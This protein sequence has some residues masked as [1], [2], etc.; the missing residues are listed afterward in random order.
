MSESILK[1]DQISKKYPGVQALKDINLEITRGE[2]HALCG[3]NG[4][5]KSTLIKILAGVR[6][7]DGGKLYIDGEEITQFNPI[8]AKKKGVSVMYQ[9]LDLAPNLTA[10]ENIVLGSEPLTKTHMFMDKKKSYESVVALF[11]RLKISVPLTVPV[12]KLSVAQQQMIMIAKSLSFN[13]KI[14]VMDEPT[15]TLIEKDVEKLFDIVRDLKKNGMTIIY[16]SHRLEEIFEIADRVTVFRDGQQV[17]T[18]DLEGLEKCDLIRYMIG[19]EIVQDTHEKT[20][21]DAAE[22][23]LEAKNLYTAKL[24]NVSIKLHRGEILGLAGLVGSG[25]TELARAIFGADKLISGEVKLFNQ[26][27]KP[28]VSR[29]I[30]HKIGLIPEDRKIQG[31]MMNM[32]VSDNASITTLSGLFS[33]LGFINKKNERRAVAGVVK[34][35]Q[36]RPGDYTLPIKSLSGGNQQK[37]VLAKWLLADSQILLIDEPTRGIDVGAKEEIYELIYELKKQG[38]SIIVISSELPE[39]IRVSDRVAV[40]AGGEMRGYVTNVDLCEESV[41]QLAT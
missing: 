30:K 15:A 4:A 36:V 7:P 11:K 23:V 9:E 41:M 34:K 3:E 17:V 1:F 19:R 6:K 20:D 27:V 35:L 22:V 31:L 12:S 2:V 10:V 26:K 40:M 24:K 33:R 32:T 13:A 5:G 25:R 21:P 18:R 14:L 38:H 29:S 8:Y 16:I 28:R 37:I 39:V